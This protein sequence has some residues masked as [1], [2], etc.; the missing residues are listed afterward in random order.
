MSFLIDYKA[1]NGLQLK[2]LLPTCMILDG[3]LLEP[4]ANDSRRHLA[5]IQENWTSSHYSLQY[6]RRDQSKR[7]WARGET[8][9][10]ACVCH[11]H[12]WGGEAWLARTQCV[13]TVR[14]SAARERVPLPHY[15]CSRK[16]VKSVSFAWKIPLLTSLDFH[17]SCFSSVDLLFLYINL[18]WFI[19]NSES[20]RNKMCTLEETWLFSHFSSSLDMIEA[21]HNVSIEMN[22]L[23]WRNSPC[24]TCM[25]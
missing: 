6:A 3:N 25:C 8:L 15:H 24:I 22:E 14:A 4:P 21:S 17:F 2:Y 10:G 16:H 9:G 19:I 18:Q 11:V 1:L 5:A 12:W 23:L 13:R 20:I 7:R